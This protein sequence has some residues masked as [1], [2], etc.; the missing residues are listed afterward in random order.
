MSKMVVSDMAASI[1]YLDA[2]GLN[3]GVKRGYKEGMGHQ[4]INN[5]SWL[6]HQGFFRGNES[7]IVP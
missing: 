7:N 6:N 5:A 3:K 2:M 1:F 4:L